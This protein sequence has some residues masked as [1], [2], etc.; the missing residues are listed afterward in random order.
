MKNKL[1]FAT[2]I[3]AGFVLGARAGRETYD[4]L[5]AKAEELW[6]NPKV[7]DT[8]SSTTDAVKHRAPEVQERASEAV[9]AAQHKASSTLHKEPKSIDEKADVTGPSGGHPYQVEEPPFQNQADET[10]PDTSP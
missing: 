9:K 2:G 7:Q 6:S 8:V 5:M 1:I 4:K 3:A 10:R